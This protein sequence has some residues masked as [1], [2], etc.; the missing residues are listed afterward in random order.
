[1]EFSDKVAVITG[2]AQGF[3]KE[4][5][6]VLVQDGGVVILLDT[7]EAL[8][9]QTVNGLNRKAICA[10]GIGCDIRDEDAVEDAIVQGAAEFG[11]IDILI[12]NAALHLTEYSQPCLKLPRDKWRN[13]LDVNLTG[14]VNCTAACAP[15]MANSGGGVVLNMSS[16]AGVTPTGAYGVSKLAVRGL[17]VALAK[18]LG[19]DGIRVV[20]IAPGFMDT[21]AAKADVPEATAYHIINNMQFVKRQGQMNDIVEAM[22]YLCSPRSSFVTG[23]TLLVTGGATPRV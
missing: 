3:G 8:L 1:M 22:R 15:H 10:L 23:E 11:H 16:M 6:E 13:M 4:F 20:G 7:N 2:G 14:I 17:T 18:E 21:P 9:E 12:N 5:A 19:P